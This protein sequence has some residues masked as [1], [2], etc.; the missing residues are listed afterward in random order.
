MTPWRSLP[1]C[2][3][4]PMVRTDL[5]DVVISVFAKVRPEALRTSPSDRSSLRPMRLNVSIDTVSLLEFLF[6]CVSAPPIQAALSGYLNVLILPVG[7]IAANSFR[8]FGEPCLLAIKTIRAAGATLADMPI[9]TRN[10]GE[11]S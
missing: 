6:F 8:V 1:F 3:C 11:I 2:F 7:L 5:L 9:W 10:A 4:I